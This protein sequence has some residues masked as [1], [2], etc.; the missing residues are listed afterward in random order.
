MGVLGLRLALTSLH[1]PTRI[2]GTRWR[3]SDVQLFGS[4]NTD[5]PWFWGVSFVEGCQKN[6]KLVRIESIKSLCAHGEGTRCGSM[7]KGGIIIR[8]KNRV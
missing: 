8:L 7:K 3:Q 1:N 5:H 4:W 2:M 6:V